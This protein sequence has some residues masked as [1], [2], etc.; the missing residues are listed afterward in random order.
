MLTPHVMLNLP[1]MVVVQLRGGG[2]S[3][4]LEAISSI[5]TM[6]LLFLEASRQHGGRVK[7]HVST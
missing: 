2:P 1:L 7:Q 6:T 4:P 3:D 5:S